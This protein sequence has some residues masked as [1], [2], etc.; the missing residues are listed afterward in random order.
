MADYFSKCCRVFNFWPFAESHYIHKWR[1]YLNHKS[2]QIAVCS[3]A[4]MQNEKKSDHTGLKAS[5]VKVGLVT[6]WCNL[7]CF[8]GLIMLCS[9]ML[10]M[11]EWWSTS[12][13]DLQAVH[14]L[15][16]WN[17]AFLCNGIIIIEHGKKCMTHP[18]Q[19]YS[20]FSSQSLATTLV[21]KNWV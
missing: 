19:P 1:F 2:V 3:V 18:F 11:A 17:S 10:C 12:A 5:D 4:F 6:L 16:Q 13:P 15:S 14:S 21:A 8:L 7:T 9:W 20:P